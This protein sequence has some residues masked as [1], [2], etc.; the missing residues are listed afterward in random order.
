MY[1]SQDTFS[2]HGQQ[3]TTNKFI[4]SFAEDLIWNSKEIYFLI[5]KQM[6]INYPIIFIMTL[7]QNYFK[8]IFIIKMLILIGLLSLTVY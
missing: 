4:K 5:R 1:I 8:I 2:S 7:R 3:L 6:T